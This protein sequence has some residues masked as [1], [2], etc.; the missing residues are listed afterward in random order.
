M[1]FG[2]KPLLQLKELSWDPG[3]REGSQ[4]DKAWLDSASSHSLSPQTHGTQSYA[5][6][7]YIAALLLPSNG[8]VSRL[9]TLLGRITVHDRVVPPPQTQLSAS[10]VPS[11]AS[12]RLEPTAYSIK[13]T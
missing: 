5:S 8:T 3:Q 12:L 7:G 9:Q 1:G 4:Q 13:M 10:T 11:K 6:W 2:T